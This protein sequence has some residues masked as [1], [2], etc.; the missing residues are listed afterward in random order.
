M[1]GWQKNTEPVIFHAPRR[2][3]RGVFAFAAASPLATCSRG[4]FPATI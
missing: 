4:H 3:L 1:A 2:Q